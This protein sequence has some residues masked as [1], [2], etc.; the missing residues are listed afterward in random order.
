MDKA[1][2]EKHHVIDRYLLNQLTADERDAFEQRFLDDPQLLDQLEQAEAMRSGLREATD[3]LK[4]RDPS[5]GRLVGWFA[6]PAVAYGVAGLAIASVTASVWLMTE[7]GR[8]GGAPQAT[9]LRDDVW[10]ETMRGAADA[11]RVS[12]PAVIRV[13]VGPPPHAERYRLSIAR[14]TNVFA[15]VGNLTVDEDNA[16]SVVISQLPAGEYEVSVMADD[17]GANAGVGVT[18]VISV[19]EPDAR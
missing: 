14:D 12:Q 7:L 11:V 18:Y 16:V 17:E 4:T 19:T 8:A 6:K 2:I 3:T 13:D 15:E 1:Y 5:R 9:P 10:L